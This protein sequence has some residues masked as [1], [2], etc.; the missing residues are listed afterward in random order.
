MTESSPKTIQQILPEIRRKL[1]TA[2][3]ILLYLSV[4]LEG[5]NAPQVLQHLPDDQYQSIAPYLESILQIPNHDR[6]YS[7]LDEVQILSHPDPHRGLEEMDGSWILHYL[8]DE[9][10]AVIGLIL[11]HLPADK[12]YQIINRLDPTIRAELPDNETLDSVSPEI[13]DIVRKRFELQLVRFPRHRFP[14]ALNFDCLLN[15]SCQDVTQLVRDI[16]LS[17]AAMAFQ[18]VN[19]RSIIELVKNLEE[20]EAEKLYEK[21]NLNTVINRGEIKAAQLEVLSLSLDFENSSDFIL[22]A[23]VQRLA[24]ALIYEDNE[25][26]EL[27]QHK[28]P[29]KTGYQLQR[30]VTDYRRGTHSAHAIQ[31]IQEDIVNRIFLLSRSGEIEPSWAKLPRGQQAAMQMI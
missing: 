5:E 24:R 18:G 19:E 1:P 7:L 27:L 21:F 11:R 31:K 14:Q 15:L 13:I 29:L 2:D 4:V 28:L 23:G 16:G 17:L 25:I 22:E 10:P 8:K 6:Y 12:V 26:V 30:Y 9:K 3:S 20:E